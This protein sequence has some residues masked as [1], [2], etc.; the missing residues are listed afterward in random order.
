MSSYSFHDED[1]DDQKP[2]LERKN[3]V[4]HVVTDR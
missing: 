3:D 1:D 2:L 4:A